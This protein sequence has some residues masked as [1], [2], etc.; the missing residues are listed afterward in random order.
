[1]SKVLTDLD[2][3]RVA[4]KLKVS[5]PAIKAVAQVE[6]AGGGFLSNGKLK[7]LFER[8]HFHR[9]TKGKY[10]VTHPQISSKSAG[11]YFGGAKEWNRF[12]E[13]SCDA[14]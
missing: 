14:L 9:L 11:G 7:I 4:K 10:S 2:Y 8:H 6:S 12:N 13:A 5:V 3:C 1:M